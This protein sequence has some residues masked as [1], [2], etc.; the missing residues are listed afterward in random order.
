MSAT[1][2]VEALAERLAIAGVKRI[3]GLPGGEMLDILEATRQAGIQ[4]VL[5]HHEAAAAFMAAA[6]GRHRRSLAACISTIGPGAT[7]LVTGIAHAYL[8]RCPVIALTADLPTTLGQDHTHQRLDLP[9]LFAPVTKGSYTLEAKSAVSVTE[10]AIALATT[11]PFGPVSLHIPRDVAL[12]QAEIPT[13]PAH[14][15]IPECHGNLSVEA[16]A[17]KL[18]QAERPLVIVGLGTPP[19]AAEAIRHFVEVYGAPAGVTP[20]VKGILYGRHPLF[21]GTYGGMMAETVLID[22]IRERDLIFCVGV[23]PT[24]LDRDWPAKERFVWLLPSLSVGQTKL[25][26]IPGA[27]NW[28][29]GYNNSI[30]LCRAESSMAMLKPLIFVRRYGPSWKK[31]FQ[32]NQLVCRLSGLLRPWRRYG[33]PRSGCVAMSGLINS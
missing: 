17:A 14:I 16:V 15:S 19:A 22:F 27:A 24:E 9:R 33:L 29:N 7:N 6:E 21:T 11:E 12:Q 10:A 26:S 30:C 31:A 3:Y 32:L 18:N 2:V 20:K 23:D 13:T 25:Q 4:F 28:S 8:D 5:V 1:T